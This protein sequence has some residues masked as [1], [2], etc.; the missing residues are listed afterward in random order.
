MD[1]PRFDDESTAQNTT[2]ALLFSSGTT[3]KW[4]N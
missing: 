1:W 2:A 4:P 3:G